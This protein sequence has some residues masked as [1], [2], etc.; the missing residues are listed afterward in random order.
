MFKILQLSPSN[1]VYIQIPWHDIWGASGFDPCMSLA[2]CFPKYTQR[3]S[4][5]VKSFVRWNV[6]HRRGMEGS[7]KFKY[8]WENN[9]QSL[10]FR[11]E[12]LKLVLELT[13]P[14]LLEASFALDAN[15]Q[16]SP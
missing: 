6:G 15:S 9:V 1:L 4:P 12:V 16:S 5:A 10:A 7:L 14:E 11:V 2:L 8:I 13:A 3:N